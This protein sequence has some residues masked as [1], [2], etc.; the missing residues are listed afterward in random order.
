MR[1]QYFSDTDTLYIV[2]NDNPVD[3]TRDLDEN[4]MFD[5]DRE[6]N[7][8]SLTIEHAQDRVKISSFSFEQ[9]SQPLLTA[10]PER[11]SA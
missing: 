5:L 2:L 7:L 8:V 4:T 10:V 9:I 3:E 11:Q 6:G 1:V